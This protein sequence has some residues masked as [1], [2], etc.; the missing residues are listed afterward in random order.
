MWV[1]TAWSSC[2][3]TAAGMMF[4]SA[5]LHAAAPCS[6]FDLRVFRRAVD[7]QHQKSLPL[8]AVDKTFVPTVS[9]H[10]TVLCEARRMGGLPFIGLCT[11]QQ[12]DARLS[13]GFA[14]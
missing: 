10:Q 3:H 9:E 13:I 6:P 7:V 12:E 14:T 4:G 1:S 8:I 11:A 5:S 2:F